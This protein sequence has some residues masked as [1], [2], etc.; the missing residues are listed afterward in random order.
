M[1]TEGGEESFR[2]NGDK[3][4]GAKETKK[5]LQGSCG[6]FIM[7]HV[8]EGAAV[9]LNTRVTSSL[10]WVK[11]GRGK[12]GK[13]QKWEGKAAVAASNNAAQRQRYML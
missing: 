1:A 12:L 7:L 3:K 8:G 11:R 2:G 4:Y 13:Q 5:E 10:E 6:P 9:G